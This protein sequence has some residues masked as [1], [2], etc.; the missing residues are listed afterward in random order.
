[1]PNR[2][3]MNNAKCDRCRGI[4]YDD[5]GRRYDDHG[6]AAVSKGNYGHG[7]GNGSAMH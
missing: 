2:P 6:R 7:K 3:P 1:M 5:F 4:D